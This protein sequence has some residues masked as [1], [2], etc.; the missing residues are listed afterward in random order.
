MCDAGDKGR[1]LN[2]GYSFWMETKNLYA[3]WLT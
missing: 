1:L 2:L 3:M